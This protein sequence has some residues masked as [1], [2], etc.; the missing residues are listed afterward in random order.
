MMNL[1]SKF[2]AEN[3]RADNSPAFLVRLE[4]SVVFNDQT[5]SSDWQANTGESNVDYVIIIGD[6]KLVSLPIPCNYASNAWSTLHSKSSLGVILA[7]NQHWQSFKRIQSPAMT[8]TITTVKG[9]FRRTSGGGSVTV[10]LTCQVWTQGKG[11]SLGTVT[12]PGYALNQTGE[13]LTFDF[14]SQ[15]IQLSDN[16]EYW[17]RWTASYAIGFGLIEQA[18]QNSDVYANGQFDRTGTSP[19]TNLGDLA[20]EATYS[21]IMDNAYYLAQ[22]YIRTRAMDI[23]QTPV[24]P[25]EWSFSDVVPAYTTLVYEAWASNTGAF[26]GEETSLGTVHDGDAIS[27]LK[28]YYMVKASF[29]T[30]NDAYTPVLQSIRASFPLFKTFSDRFSLWH[31][32]AVMGVT[33]LSS[34]IDAFQPSTISQITLRLALTKS[35]SS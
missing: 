21:G 31:E 23:G 5:A 14:T 10:N 17:L 22:G 25:G 8:K 12:I 18:Y 28:R 32:P 11:A 34:T 2:A 6:V 27:L 1:P 3:R 20:F 33:S 4:D 19:G 26:A 29:S 7:D 30:T 16:T 24:E 9:Y 13:W 15:N 35:V